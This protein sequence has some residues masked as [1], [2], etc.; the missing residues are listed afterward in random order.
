M[1]FNK[2]N[3]IINTNLRS[4]SKAASASTESFALLRAERKAGQKMGR[5]GQR[6][7]AKLK[8]LLTQ[9]QRYRAESVLALS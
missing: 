9:C 3:L 6:E 5:G 1:V 4:G 2:H 8:Y 7:R